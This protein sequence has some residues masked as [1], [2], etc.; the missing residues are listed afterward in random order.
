MY[1]LSELL[2]EDQRIE[3]VPGAL[4]LDVGNKS[5][6][7]S[8]KF[9]KVKFRY[10][11]ETKSNFNEAEKEMTTNISIENDLKYTLGGISF[12]IKEGQKTAIVGHTG[13]GKS[14]IVRMLFRF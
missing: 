8:I 14:T 9:E 5:H 7:A 6:G 3:D 11:V 10:K 2:K 12:E 13:S 4:E 1:N